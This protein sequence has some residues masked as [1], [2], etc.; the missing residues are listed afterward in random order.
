MT[1]KQNELKIKQIIK[2]I[3]DIHLLY[4][5]RVESSERYR[6]QT[7]VQFERIHHKLRQYDDR[8]IEIDKYTQY[9]NEKL[10][11]LFGLMSQTQVNPTQV[12]VSKFYRFR[13]WLYDKIDPREET[14]E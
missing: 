10:E 4:K 9:T 12:K 8:I 5:D 1:V 11:R 13:V 2:V 7:V 14:D 3:D 6:D